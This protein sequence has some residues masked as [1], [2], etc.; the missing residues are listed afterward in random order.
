MAKQQRNGPCSCGSGRKFKRCCYG[1]LGQRAMPPHMAIVLQELEAQERIRERQQ[2]KG[3]PIIAVKDGDRQIVA[4]NNRLISGMGWKTFA[5]FL[6]Y[7]IKDRLG[8]EW[9]QAEIGKPLNERHII[10]QWY[11]AKCRY[12]KRVM[13]GAGEVQSAPMTGVLACYFG[14]AYSLYLMDHNADLQAKMIARL[15]NPDQFQGAFFEMLVA[16]ALIRAGYEL[17]L[18]DEDSRKT[19]HCEF[20]AIKRDNGKRYT[21]EAKSRTVAGFLGSKQGNDENP[22]SRLR[23]HLHDALDKPSDH[24]RLVFIDIN[25]PVDIADDAANEA[26]LLRAAQ[27]LDYYERHPDAPPH[28]AYVFLVNAAFHRN[29]DH[30][31]IVLVLPHGYRIPDFNKPTPIPV[32]ERYRQDQKHADIYEIAKCFHGLDEL[33][34]TF[35]GSLPSET[36]HGEIARMKI[37]GVYEFEGPNGLAQ[38]VVRSATVME[39]DK[40][41][42]ASVETKDGHGLYT[43][44]MSDA[45]FED[46]LANKDSYFGKVLDVATN[47]KTPLEVYARFMEMFADYDRK[48]LALQI[49]RKPY[50][51]L[52]AHLSDNEL[53]EQVSNGLLSALLNKGA[54]GH[55]VQAKPTS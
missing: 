38:G 40:T 29:L 6:Q 21:V 24:E 45:A 55:T 18:E 53:R 35:D 10:M 3:K 48:A 22:L 13:N 52:L 8:F 14:L 12:Q 19:R 39:T 36:I 34:T 28:P 46:W 27:K 50:D 26:V 31:P 16:S 20:A 32:V 2:G 41:I 15:K 4:V 33:P 44:Q 42:W 25:A 30:K 23:Q 54:G 7:Y 37:G 17:V 49:G 47:P 51:P 43:E 11:D 1:K 9:G 5:D